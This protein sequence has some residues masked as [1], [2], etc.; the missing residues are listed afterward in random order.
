M[1]EKSAA[2]AAGSAAPFQISLR[3]FQGS[4]SLAHSVLSL[5]MLAAVAIV[6]FSTLGPVPSAGNLVSGLGRPF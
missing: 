4:N 2:N 6:A 3:L 5:E 1:L